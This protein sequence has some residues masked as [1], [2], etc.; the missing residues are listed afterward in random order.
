MQLFNGCMYLHPPVLQSQW[1]EHFSVT[2]SLQTVNKEE[3]VT[4]EQVRVSY[5]ET[6]TVLLGNHLIVFSLKSILFTL[7][8][9]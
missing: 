6:N 3:P 8:L 9:T 1:T 7:Y 5:K 2:Q 4:D